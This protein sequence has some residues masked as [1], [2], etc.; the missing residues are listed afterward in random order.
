M[1]AV[2]NLSAVSLEMAPIACGE[3]IESMLDPSLFIVVFM[4]SRDES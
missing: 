2:E 1:S 4:D 3:R